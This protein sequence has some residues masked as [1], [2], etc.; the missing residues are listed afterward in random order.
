METGLSKQAV[1]FAT[2][3]FLGAFCN[4]ELVNKHKKWGKHQEKKKAG[5]NACRK[6]FFGSIYAVWGKK[7]L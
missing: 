6:V 1:A 3:V 7:L 2:S 4:K 5:F